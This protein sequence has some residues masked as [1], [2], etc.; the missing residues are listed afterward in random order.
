MKQLSLALHNFYDEHRCLPPQALLS[1]DGKPLLSWRVL[2]LP[3]LEGGE[4]YKRFRLDEAWD[5]P[6]NLPLAN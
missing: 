4:L 6:N 1:K 3:Y 2:L 5:S